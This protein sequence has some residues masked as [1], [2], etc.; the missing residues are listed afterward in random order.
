MANSFVYIVPIGIT[1]I[2]MIIKAILRKVSEFEGAHTKSD[3]VFSSL[4]KMFVV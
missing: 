2:N 1:I 4:V 3:M